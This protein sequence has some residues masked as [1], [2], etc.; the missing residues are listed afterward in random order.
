MPH[1]ALLERE[2]PIAHLAHEPIL[3]AVQLLRVV[4]L[5]VRGEVSF[6]GERLRAVL[7]AVLFDVQ[8]QFLVDFE[9]GARQEALIADLAH[10]LELALVP[11]DMADHRLAHLR[12][13]LAQ[14]THVHVS[15]LE[16]VQREAVQRVKNVLADRALELVAVRGFLVVFEVVVRFEDLPA[17]GALVDAVA[18]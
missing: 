3:H 13:E 6:Y 5:D 11:H 17:E 7:A 10:P 18:F 16:V 9:G 4:E 8:V 15:V 12:R 14:R 2:R 1:Q